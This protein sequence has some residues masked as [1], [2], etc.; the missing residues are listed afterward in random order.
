MGVLS[1]F[2]LE[3]AGDRTWEMIV[4]ERL[5]TMG[6]FLFGGA[7]LGAAVAVAEEFAEKPLVWATAQY[8]SFAHPG[9]RLA[10]KLDERARG[11]NLVQLGVRGAVGDREVFSVLCALGRR[12][13]EIRSTW[14]RRPLVPPPTDCPPRRRRDGRAPTGVSAIFGEALA[15]GRQPDELDGTPGDG[16]SA[17][18]VGLPEGLPV[19]AS[20]LAIVADHVPF[21]ISQALGEP[22]GGTSLDNTLRIV[23]LSEAEHVLVEVEIEAVAAGVAHGSARLWS[24]G[25]DLL[26]LASQT[27]AMRRWT[28]PSASEQRRAI[29]LAASDR[30]DRSEVRETSGGSI[31]PSIDRNVGRKTR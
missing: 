11:S 9:E 18:W 19:C 5:C 10:L 22:Y 14:V 15:I 21:G 30:N 24:P 3:Q 20:V 28:S 17:L 16:R 25:G 2:G 27:A 23:G 1:F 12:R 31:D 26:A 4:H 13:E 8:S 29:T 7:A 6:G